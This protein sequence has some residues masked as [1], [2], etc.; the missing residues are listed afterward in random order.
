MVKLIAEHFH[1]KLWRLAHG[2]SLELGPRAVIM[3]I[4]NVTPDSFSDGDRYHSPEQ[5]LDAAIAMVDAGAK[6]IDVGGE[7]TRPG[8]R[9]I[10]AQEEQD[11]VLPIV[12]SLAGLQNALISVDTYRADTARLAINAGAHIINDVWGFQKDR[13][14]AETCASLQAGCCL[15]HSGRERKRNPDVIP[16]QLSYLRKSLKIA[17]N[18]GIPAE[19]I[20]LDAGFGFAKNV[21]ENVALL[22]HLSQ[23]HALGYPQIVGTSRKRFLG[24]IAEIEKAE[25][26][27]VATAAT[28][29]IARLQGGAIFRVHDVAKNREAL[30]VADAVIDA[31]IVEKT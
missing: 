31:Q 10:T 12:A 30:A 4:L 2:R 15:M 23:L 17:E 27:D 14:M 16:D 5:A 11:R 29:V 8:A 3:G 24:A 25:E 1:S 9:A 20:T 26:R 6:I 18:A 21:E 22:A 7:S 28:S 13:D 19:A